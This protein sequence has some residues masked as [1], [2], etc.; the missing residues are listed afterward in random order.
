MYRYRTRLFAIS[1]VLA[2][3]ASFSSTARADNEFDVS[4][5][6]GKVTVT[7][8]TGWHINKEYPWKLVV[9]EAKLDKT[10]FNLAETTA[11]VADAPKGSGT[12]KGA[13]C[14]ADQCHSFQKDV[15]IQ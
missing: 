9:G 12:I 13:V 14:S 15:T 1:S 10:K 7:A 2:V 4:V 5:A 8:H 6:N 11:T 3:A